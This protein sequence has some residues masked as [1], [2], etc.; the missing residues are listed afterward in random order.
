M[1]PHEFQ[2]QFTHTHKHTQT[3]PTPEKVR[4]SVRIV[5][6]LRVDVGRIG[7]FTVLTLLVREHGT[8][9]HLF[10]SSSHPAVIVCSLGQRRGL[11]YLSLLLLGLDFLKCYHK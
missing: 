3:D 6:D 11:E 2:Y 10:K 9:F 8:S 1:F 4:T 5:S 7:L